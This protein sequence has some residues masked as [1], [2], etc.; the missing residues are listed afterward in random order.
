MTDKTACTDADNRRRQSSVASDVRTSHLLSAKYWKDAANIS[1]VI[2]IGASLGAMGLDAT[3]IVFWVIM[4]PVW[5]LA[6]NARSRY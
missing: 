6:R 5:A 2:A 4:T 1:F 3:K